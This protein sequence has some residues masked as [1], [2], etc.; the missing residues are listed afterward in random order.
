MNL[1]QNSKIEFK[2]VKLKRLSKYYIMYNSKIIIL[3]SKLI[4]IFLFFIRLI[5]QC[6][7]I[8]NAPVTGRCKFNSCMTKRILKVPIKKIQYVFVFGLTKALY[9]MLKSL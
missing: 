3:S 4:W 2:K 5:M 1:D 8:A 9:I 6:R 7:I